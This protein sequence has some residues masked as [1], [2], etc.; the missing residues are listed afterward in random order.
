MK[1]VRLVGILYDTD[2]LIINEWKNLSDISIEEIIKDINSNNFNY[3][4]WYLE[5]KEDGKMK[6]YIYDDR[7]NKYEIIEGIIPSNYSLWNAHL[8]KVDGK[9]FVKLYN[10]DLVVDYSVDTDTLLAIEVSEEEGKIIDMCYCSGGRNPQEVKK[11]L[12]SKDKWTR[13]H[14][15][16][17][18]PYIEKLFNVTI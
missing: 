2:E 4:D 18:K 17:I 6:K 11:S 12:K 15:E 3:Y 9:T 13:Q 5:Y 1:Q 14:A 10:N 8:L 16:M 7:G